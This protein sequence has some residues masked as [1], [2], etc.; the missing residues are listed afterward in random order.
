VPT[1][2]YVGP[3]AEAEVVLLGRV[4]KRGDTFTVDDADAALLLEQPDNFA[5]VDD[6]EL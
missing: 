5:P 4:V 3:W 1:F 6:K 2:E